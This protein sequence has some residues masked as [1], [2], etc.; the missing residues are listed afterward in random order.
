M[1]WD[2]QTA[3]IIASGPSLTIEDCAT[4]QRWHEA[5]G[6]RVIAINMSY[7]RAPWAD[8]LYACDGRW[9]SGNVTAAKKVF[10]GEHWTQD[11]K[12]ANGYGLNYIKSDRGEGLNRK[13]G[14]INQGLNSGFQS[15]NL[16]YHWGV[17][18]IVLL[19]YDM[20]HEGKRTHWHPPHQHDV[21]TPFDRCIKHFQA[22]A[23]DL[24]NDGVVVV[25]C[26]RRTALK[27]W[28]M[29]DLSAEMGRVT[30]MAAD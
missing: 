17:R 12:A 29:G 16:A 22:I 30:K 24:A 3:V 20:S 9:W 18:R 14:V 28:P 27:C 15:I 21:Q 6:G 23:R 2:G 5:G 19:G 25:N 11:E 26:T 10:H 1:K 4:V 8:V 7:Q 13:P